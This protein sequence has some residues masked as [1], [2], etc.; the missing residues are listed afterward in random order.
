MSFFLCFVLSN[1]TTSLLGKLKA[2]LK[3]YQDRDIPN[4]M[5][6]QGHIKNELLI[7]FRDASQVCCHAPF[8]VI[9]GLIGVFR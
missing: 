1:I 6:S 4:L 9:S 5:R 8:F 7:L 3:K 2:T